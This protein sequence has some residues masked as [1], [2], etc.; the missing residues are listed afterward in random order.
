M[1][2]GSIGFA[3]YL[4]AAAG[5]KS[6]GRMILDLPRTILE[7]AAGVVGGVA[8]TATHILP[9]AFEGIGEGLISDPAD[10]GYYHRTGLYSTVLVSE[11]IATGAAIGAMH[12]GW[13]GALLGGSGGLL[14]GLIC[15]GI[16]GKANVPERF[17]QNVDT[18]VDTAIAGNTDGSKIKIAV[19]NATQGFI[20]G[21]GIGI[22][23]GYQ[24]G[25]E[26]GKGLVGGVLD[27]AY[28]TLE[29]I[30]EAVRGPKKH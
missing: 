15:R 1:N 18:A 8:G 2:I 5:Q 3:P 25:R 10:R 14:T 22:K 4:T 29:G 21:T 7:E 27:V 13:I 26:S 6:I 30:F 9:G 12:G 17:V 23:D 11:F 16:E 20:L 19:Q 24:T 28:G